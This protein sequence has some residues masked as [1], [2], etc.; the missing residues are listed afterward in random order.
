MASEATNPGG[1]GRSLETVNPIEV[2]AIAARIG[3]GIKVAVEPVDRSAD[4][5]FGPSGFTRGSGIQTLADRKGGQTG[6]GHRSSRRI[7]E[8]AV[9][10]TAIL[11]LPCEE[12]ASDDL[13]QSIWNV[14]ASSRSIS[15]RLHRELGQ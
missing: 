1:A 9:S 7:R 11:S 10:P 6:G 13:D 15:D 8:I 5:D 14:E 12:S 2:P 3:V 4:C